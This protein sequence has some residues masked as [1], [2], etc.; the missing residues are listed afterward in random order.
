[1]PMPIKKITAA[2]FWKG[3]K[4]KLEEQV[5]LVIFGTIFTAGMLWCGS[6]LRFLPKLY[7]DF[8][9]VQQNYGDLLRRV[10]WLEEQKTIDSAKQVG[11]RAARDKE[12]KELKLN[13]K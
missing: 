8:P 3:I 13:L 1:M 2:S 6:Y 9:V 5:V 11:Y 12:I 4:R 10:T 7:H